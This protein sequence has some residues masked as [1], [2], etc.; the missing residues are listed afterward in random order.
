MKRMG[1]NDQK[2]EG[3]IQKLQDL[4]REINEGA[5]N[6]DELINELS[7]IV[8]GLTKESQTDLV[9]NSVKARLK[10]TN[11]S[12]N[13]DPSFDVEDNRGFEIRSFI[14]FD[15][16]IPVGKCRAIPTGLYFELDKGLEVQIR[17]RFGLAKNKGVFVLNS[18]GNNLNQEVEVILANF[19]DF[20]ITVQNG[21][22]IAQGFVCPVYGEGYLKL[23]KIEKLPDSEDSNVK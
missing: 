10:F 18:P 6:D 11:L 20:A 7:R 23:E 19:G 2:F 1:K 5:D 9:N 16:H 13:P 21:D 8:D 17:S 3:Y 22:K 12:D 4:E 15:L 14:P